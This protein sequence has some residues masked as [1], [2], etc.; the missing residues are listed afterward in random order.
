MHSSDSEENVERE[1]EICF[2]IDNKL[3]KDEN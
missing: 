1:A 2:K 3:D